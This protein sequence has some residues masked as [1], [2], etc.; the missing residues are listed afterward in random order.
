M[1]IL[2]ID[3]HSLF[4][5]GLRILLNDFDKALDIVCCESCEM[6]LEQAELEKVELILLDYFLPGLCGVEALVSLLSLIH[7]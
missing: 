2:L 7:I 4:A 1:K 3:D 6:A 5:E